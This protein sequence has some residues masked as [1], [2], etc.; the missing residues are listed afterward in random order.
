MQFSNFLVCVLIFVKN[1]LVIRP[2][3]ADSLSLSPKWFFFSFR[4]KMLQITFGADKMPR[5]CKILPQQNRYPDLF[6]EILQNILQKGTFWRTF[7]KNSKTSYNWEERVQVV[8]ASFK[9]R[10]TG[11]NSFKRVQVVKTSSPKKFE[12]NKTNFPGNLR[13]VLGMEMLVRCEI[14]SLNLFIDRLGKQ[15]DW[16]LF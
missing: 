8:L 10:K 15:S 11:H 13:K 7:P 1:T 16:L 2:S 5:K 12:K 4:E 3:P 9:L 14:L 6:L